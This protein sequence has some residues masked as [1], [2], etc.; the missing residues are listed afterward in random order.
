MV[1]TTHPDLDLQSS[2]RPGLDILANEIVIGLK[3]RT[4]FHQNLHLYQ[5]GLVNGNPDVALLD[6][7]LNRVESLHAE[8]GRYTFASQES[9]TD[10]SGVSPVIKR[11]TPQSPI[12]RVSSGA[13]TRIL[14]FYKSWVGKSC[15]NGEKPETYGETVT[16]DTNVL[17]SIIER[18]NLGK[19]VAES[20]FLELTP[21]FLQAEGNRE[22]MLALIVRKDREEKVLALAENLA[23]HYD[24]NVENI[25]D[26]FRFMITTTVD[27]EVEYLN[28]RIKNFN[29]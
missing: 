19:L 24:A 23:K 16:A 10:V 29:G 3:K 26:V 17:L 18:V 11:Q 2:I 21:Q 6:Y 14:D 4:R 25:M 28:V 1:A 15:P 8:L 22:K 27:I 7:E 20:K 9:Y 13:S 5:P 12:M